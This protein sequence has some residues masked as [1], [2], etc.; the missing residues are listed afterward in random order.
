MPAVNNYGTAYLDV[1]SFRQSAALFGVG[2][3]LSCDYP[4]STEG[5]TAIAFALQAASRHIDAFCA[6]TFTPEDLK[7]Q[8][9]FDPATWRFQVNN[10]PVTEIVSCAIRYGLNSTITILP[11][12]IYVCNQQKYLEIVRR[13]ESL[14]TLEI[15]TELINPVIEVV[16]K[17]LQTVPANVQLACGYQAAHLINEG[18]VDKMLPPNFGKLDLTGLS[19]N[20][21]KG[22]KSSGEKLA[23]TIS[24][25]AERL[26]ISERKISIA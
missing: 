6:R 2:M 4:E 1:E 22:Y 15:G 26:L 13:L 7:E 10:P 8:H 11:A 18:F 19:I 23:E 9:L 20:N 25:G 3:S 21:K 12:D 5:N 17:S 24:P 14:T 16:Y